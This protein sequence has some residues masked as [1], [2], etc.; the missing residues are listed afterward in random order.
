[1]SGGTVGVR[2]RCVS[3]P[4]RAG[5]R[6]RQLAK[7]SDP[8]YM[9]T[10]PLTPEMKSHFDTLVQKNKVVLFMKGNKHFPQCGFSA[11]L[12]GMLTELVGKYETVNVLADPAVRDGIKEY[13][14]W[15][16]IPQLYVDGQFVGGCDIVTDMYSSGE[17]QKL[18]GG[19]A[20]KVEVPTI[21]LSA[22]AVKALK[23]ATSEPGDD[24]L[25][26]EIAVLA[27][28]AFQHELFFAP[29]KANDMEVT[30]SGVTFL[31]DPASA[32]RANGLAID[33]VETADGGA[34]KLENPNEPPRVKA[35]SVKE[36]KGLIDKGEKL[37][38]FDVRTPDERATAKIA[39]SVHLDEAGEKRLLGLPKDAR[40]VFHCHHGGR[41]RAAAERLVKEGWRNVYNLEGGIDA[42]SQQVDSTVKRY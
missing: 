35:M 3:R 26:L 32:K 1:M 40:I 30:A 4:R 5:A 8:N 28:G 29:K 16:T 18:L 17:L 23:D 12:A 41:S 10:M 20:P 9:R 33:F 42:W 39:S 36:L 2:S 34:F 13:S 22:G 37:E 7:I 14:S 19:E 21:T 24:R 15:P 25:R 38:L 27:Q 6:T 31:V 11:K